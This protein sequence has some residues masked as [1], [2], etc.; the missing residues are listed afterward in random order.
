MRE[1]PISRQAKPACMNITRIA[2]TITHV[3]LTLETVS[4]RL[5]PSA[6]KAAPGRNRLTSR[7]S[8]PSGP[9]ALMA[10]FIG[11]VLLLVPPVEPASRPPHGTVRSACEKDR[12]ERRS[13][14]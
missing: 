1:K 6:A 4:V 3:V 10:R 7:A 12:F 5:G 11:W 14:L 8:A 9:P 2:A 13:D